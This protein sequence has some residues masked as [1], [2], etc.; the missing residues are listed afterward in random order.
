MGEPGVGALNAAMG[1][2][3]LAR[4]AAAITLAGR[5]RLS[6]AFN[7]SLAGLGC[8]DRDHRARRRP[9]V[10]LLAM[11]AI[12]VS[13]AFIDVSGFTLIQRMTPNA[14]RIAVLGLLDSVAN[15][16]VVLGGILAPFL[17]EAL[18]IQGALIVDRA[19]PAGREHPDRSRHCAG[20]TR[21]ASP[22]SRP[23]RAHPRRPAP[24]AAVAGHGRAPGGAPSSRST[25]ADGEWLMREGEPGDQTTS[26]ST[27]GAW[28]C[29]RPA[30]RV[31]TLGPGQRRRR[32]RADAGRAEDGLGSR[33]RVR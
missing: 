12:G 30:G 16:G 26:S 25:F 22:T 24:R 21:A 18:G 29:R 28:R 19:D 15:G 8:P 13:N 7:L 20:R 32:D 31:R 9:R 17:I 10:A 5:D 6:P 3:G 4:A 23:G 33:D 1:L 14:S 27:P 2:G 11:V